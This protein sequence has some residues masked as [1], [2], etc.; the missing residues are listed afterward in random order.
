MLPS[1]PE[2]AVSKQKAFRDQGPKDSVS[3]N[4]EYCYEPDIVVAATVEEGDHKWDADNAP[5]AIGGGDWIAHPIRE[6][7]RAY[8]N[9]DTENAGDAKQSWPSE[10]RGALF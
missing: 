1:S 6:G 3:N 2:V 8:A 4:S 7:P 5:C 9:D 10:W